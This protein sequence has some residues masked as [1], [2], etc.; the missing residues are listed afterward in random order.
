MLHM[1]SFHNF[2][3]WHCK[4][5]AHTVPDTIFMASYALF[6]WHLDSCIIMTSLSNLCPGC[7]SDYYGV[8]ISMFSVTILLCV[9]CRTF[10]GQDIALKI[11]SLGSKKHR[12]L[13]H[14]YTCLM[15]VRSLWGRC[16]PSLELAGPLT[17]HGHGFGLG[18]SLL[19]GRHP[20][21]GELTLVKCSWQVYHVYS[22]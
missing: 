11:A 20:K 18:T 15:A 10:G 19:C 14:Q 9:L 16:V 12:S 3:H 1:Q 4:K 8:Y 22:K 6:A 13:K 5:C 7:Q 17:G 2:M 21:P